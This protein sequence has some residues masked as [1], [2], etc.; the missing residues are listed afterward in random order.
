MKPRR[1]S[2]GTCCGIIVLVFLLWA[3]AY[4]LICRTVVEIPGPLK[5]DSKEVTLEM[6][7]I[8][9]RWEKSPR[10]Y[11]SIPAY[12]QGSFNYRLVL[13]NSVRRLRDPDAWSPKIYGWHEG[14]L[15]TTLN[16]P[17]GRTRMLSGTLYQY[18]L[19]IPLW[20]L[21]T[22]YV[23]TWWSLAA[24][25]RRRKIRAEWKKSLA[26]A[27]PASGLHPSKGSA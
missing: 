4:S 24:I 26:M 15:G 23:G 19:H 12:C 8:R 16:L 7:E 20:M 6:G 11:T 5:K 1:L 3:F 14:V 25:N 17:G 9:V 21:I 10:W 22:L 27:R 2:S 18:Y 13:N